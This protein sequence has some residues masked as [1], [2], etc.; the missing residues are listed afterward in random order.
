MLRKLPINKAI[1]ETACASPG[2]ILA[3]GIRIDPLSQ[4][5]AYRCLNSWQIESLCLLVHY[6]TPLFLYKAIDEPPFSVHYRV[7]RSILAGYQDT[8]WESLLGISICSAVV[9]VSREMI[10]NLSVTIGQIAEDT[11]K[12]IAAQQTALNSFAQVV[13][14]NK[15]ALDFLLA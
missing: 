4:R 5:W 3:C 6:A 7:K 15:V 2:F 8:W 9:Y 11:A 1:N 13:F 14:D 12:S 10:R